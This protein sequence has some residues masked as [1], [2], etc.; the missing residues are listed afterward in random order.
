MKS[1]EDKILAQSEYYLHTPSTLALQIYFYPL[2]IGNF[3][4]AP[5]YRLF[6]R[7]FDSFLLMLIKKGSCR[8]TTAA[9]S[10]TACRNDV[11]LLNCY[12]AHSYSTEEGF[13]A[14]WVH[15]DGVLA[16]NYYHII[17]EQASGIKLKNLDSFTMRFQDLFDRFA[18]GGAIR[19]AS[20]SSRITALLTA[21]IENTSGEKTLTAHTST[22]LSRITSYINSHMTEQLSLKDLAEQ[23]SLSMFYFS[24]LF[25]KETGYS[26][27]EYIIITRLNHACYLLATSRLSVK[28][29]C[30]ACGFTNESSFC[31]AFKKKY[32]QTPIEYRREH[33]QTKE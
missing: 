7:S 18:G 17:G 10:Y 9:A 14:L 28:E 20:V 4:Y 16:R 25:R 30:F 23:A 2:C 12:A 8:I 11:V 5:G 3:V 24:K 33:N 31:A 21:L 13:E 26:P 6:R 1:T 15:F 22:G 27:H 29:I 32:L 19:E